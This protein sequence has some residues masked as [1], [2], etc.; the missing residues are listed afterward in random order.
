MEA[1]GFKCLKL[2]SGVFVLICSGQPEVILIVY[3][4]DAVFMG[5]QKHLVNTYKEHFM[6]I[7][8][9]RD[10]GETEEFLRMSITCQKGVISL[11]QKD[12]LNT[13]LKHF[14]M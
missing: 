12:Y 13:V 8:E 4:D 14:N 10:L 5:Q 2:D 11:D 9:C 7:W 3:V 1:M 6:H